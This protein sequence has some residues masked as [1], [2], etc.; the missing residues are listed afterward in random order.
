MTIDHEVNSQSGCIAWTQRRHFPVVYPQ[1]VSTKGGWCFVAYISIDSQ[2]DWVSLA[3]EALPTYKFEQINYSSNIWQ[4]TVQLPNKY[5]TIQWLYIW[6]FSSLFNT[7]SK[8]HQNT[9]NFEAVCKC[10]WKY[11]EDIV[12][13]LVPVQKLTRFCCLFQLYLLSCSTN[14]GAP[15]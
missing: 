8:H 7:F 15:T 5:L 2:I 1:Y 11:L 13:A 14:S 10:E 4:M 3:L 6:L 9:L 12:I